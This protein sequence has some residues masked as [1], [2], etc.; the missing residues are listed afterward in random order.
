MTIDE[1]ERAAMQAARMNAPSPPSNLLDAHLYLALYSLYATLYTGQ[2]TREQAR[3]IKLKLVA[4][5]RR[6]KD[7]YDFDMKLRKSATRLW[8]DTEQAGNAY[9]RDRTLDNADRLWAAVLNLPKGS[10]PKNAG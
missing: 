7:S 6:L 1:I 3:P 4:Q 5:Y 2:L 10:R 9:A 8:R